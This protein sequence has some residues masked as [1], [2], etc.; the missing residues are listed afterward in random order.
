L[1][2][3]PSASTA[4]A[5][6]LRSRTSSR[7]PRA[8]ESATSTSLWPLATAWNSTTGFNPK[9]A[10]ANAARPGLTRSA[11][12]AITAIV[13]RLANPASHRYAST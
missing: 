10:T 3:A 5:D 6:R 4:T 13:A 8:I 9:A 1:I 12:D 7:N 2:N 11:A